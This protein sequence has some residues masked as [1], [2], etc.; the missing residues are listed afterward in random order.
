MNRNA[1]EF[2]SSPADVTKLAAAIMGADT[3][4]TGGRA[5]YL[6]SL[7]AVTQTELAGKPVL[8]IQGRPK[9]PD[10]EAAAQTFDKVAETFYAAVL[11]AVPEGLTAAERQSKTSFARSAAATLRRAIRTG[12]NPLGETAP[13]VTKGK[14]AAWVAEHSEPRPLTAKAAERRVMDH[15][16]AIADLI[17]KLPKEDAARVLAMALTDLGQPTQSLTSVSLR[18]H[19]PRAAH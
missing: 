1:A 18:R 12:W 11:A 4:A 19:E 15:V 13:S 17:D 9:R 6:R 3:S 8:K 5:T 16:G 2:V 7:L 14:L 10:M